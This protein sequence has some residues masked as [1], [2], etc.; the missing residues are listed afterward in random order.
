MTPTSDIFTQE[1]EDACRPTTDH[2]RQPERIHDR[3]GQPGYGSDRPNSTDRM[4]DVALLPR[5]KIV[6]QA[7][8][9]AARGS[10]TSAQS[11]AN[12]RS[13]ASGSHRTSLFSTSST[14]TLDDMSR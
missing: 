9:N 11:T 10:R 3:E 8:T 1:A 12:A 2:E 5:G 4:H 13:R 6:C 14:V 7:G